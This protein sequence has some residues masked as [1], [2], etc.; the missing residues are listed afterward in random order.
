[1]RYPHIASLLYGQPWC[2]LP[3]KFD[4]ITAA[5]ELLRSGARYTDAEVQAHI[6][7]AGRREPG[8]MRSQGALA[9]IPI[10]GT[11]AQKGGIIQDA[12][13]G[14]STEA[15]SAMLSQALADPGVA[16]ILLDVS[17]PGGGTYGVQEL[18]QQIYDARGSK[19]ICAIANSMAASAAYW[20]ACAADEVVVTPGGEVGSIG[21]YMIYQDASKALEAEGIATTIIKAGAFKAEATGLNPLTA[22]ATAALQDRVDE[23]YGQFCGMV[24]KG[25][26][27][28]IAQVRDGMGQGRLVSAKAAIAAGMAD[29]VATFDQT[30]ARLTGGARGPAARMRAQ[31][32]PHMRAYQFAFQS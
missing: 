9:V 25:R 1:M 13:G 12:S 4:V 30:V 17:S 19:P 16:S 22:E 23:V 26:S 28:P 2:I 7:A 14:T 31:D 6:E 21:A 24:A 29:R 5:F 3:E 10:Y 11:I 15:V 8:G 20:I 18:A 27:V 32:D